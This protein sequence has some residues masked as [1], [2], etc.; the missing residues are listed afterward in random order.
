[1][2]EL[3]TGNGWA[4]N[5]QDD[6]RE[7]DAGKTE[8]DGEVGVPQHPGLHVFDEPLWS[9]PAWRHPPNSVQHALLVGHQFKRKGCKGDD[10]GEESERSDPEFPTLVDPDEDGDDRVAK[11]HEAVDSTRDGDPDR[12][13]SGLPDNQ[14]RDEQRPGC[15]LGKCEGS[16]EDS[17]RYRSLGHSAML[18]NVA[19]TRS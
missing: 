10:C 17:G 9:I 11:K 8:G 19:P 3:V 1:M 7:N 12:V 2:S 15:Y 13:A 14:A 5:E 4:E 18:P 16:E 6:V